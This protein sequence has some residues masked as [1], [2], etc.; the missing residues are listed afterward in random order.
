MKRLRLFILIICLI[1]FRSNAQYIATNNIP[2]LQQLPVNAIHRIFQDKEGYMW[3]STWG[4]LW[5]S[6]FDQPSFIV[7]FIKDTPKEYPLPTLR[8][9]VNCNPAI[10][11]LADSGDGIMWLSQERTGVCLYDIKNTSLKT[12]GS[13]TTKPN[14]KK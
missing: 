13:L 12:R 11:S 10:M 3:V 4:N 9:K 2:C 7:H 1:L 5:V 6:A 14:N 8:R